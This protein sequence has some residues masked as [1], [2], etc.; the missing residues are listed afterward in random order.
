MSIIN[1]DWSM[2]MQNIYEGPNLRW[3]HR[4]GATTRHKTDGRTAITSGNVSLLATRP[5]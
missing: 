3:H 1:Q 2:V 5:P 4:H